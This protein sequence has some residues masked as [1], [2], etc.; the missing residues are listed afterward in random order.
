MSKSKELANQI[1]GDLNSRA[2]PLSGIVQDCLTLASIEGEREWQVYFRLQLLGV[3]VGQHPESS[4]RGSQGD[5]KTFEWQPAIRFAQDR[6]TGDNQIQAFPVEQLET[7]IREANF[8]L[9][10]G[11]DYLV[12]LM[13]RHDVFYRLQ[14][15]QDKNSLAKLV[16][17][18]QAFLVIART[19]AREFVAMIEAK[20]ST[21]PLS[22]GGG[23]AGRVFIGHGRSNAWT[24]LAL[25][26]RERLAME[27]EEF[28]REAVAGKTIVARLQEMLDSAAVAFMV[29]TGEDEHV[30]GSLH[31]RE[32]VVHE[33]GLF[34]GRLGFNKALILLEE[35]CQ[36]LSNIHG[37]VQ[38]R[39]PRGNIESKFEAIRMVLER[40][41]LLSIQRPVDST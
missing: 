36:E 19:R 8:A 16:S 28:N 27:Y 24:H 40:E 31:A 20:T 30:D 32:N 33:A 1:K 37:L 17:E 39:F 11:D 35:G 5:S 34:Q 29:L 3:T 38:I 14:S 18:S 26:L 13:K 9:S 4:P 25:F 23:S 10:T 41:G 15:L 2:S 6:E 21:T 7:F 12:D 22:L